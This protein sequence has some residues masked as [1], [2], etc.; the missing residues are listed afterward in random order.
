MILLLIFL[1]IKAANTMIMVWYSCTDHWLGKMEDRTSLTLHWHS[2]LG[3]DSDMGTTVFAHNGGHHIGDAIKSLHSPWIMPDAKAII[4]DTSVSNGSSFGP[5]RFYRSAWQQPYPIKNRRFFKRTITLR[6]P[7]LIR[8][9][10]VWYVQYAAQCGT[11][12]GRL[13]SLISSSLRKR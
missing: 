11:S 5:G 4:V 1:L 8:Q 3:G 9:F 7:I 10:S 6:S 12:F 2:F 13:L